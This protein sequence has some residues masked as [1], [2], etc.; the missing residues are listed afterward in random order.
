MEFNKDWSCIL[1]R[2]EQKY[3][4]MRLREKAR[5]HIDALRVKCF[6][7][8]IIFGF[9]A[10]TLSQM[11]M[12]FTCLRSTNPDLQFISKIRDDVGAEALDDIELFS[13]NFF[14]PLKCRLGGVF[15][16]Y[17]VPSRLALTVHVLSNEIGP[18]RWVRSVENGIKPSGRAFGIHGEAL[19]GQMRK[20]AGIFPLQYH[21]LP[22]V[23]AHLPTDELRFPDGGRGV[24]VEYQLPGPCSGEGDSSRIASVMH[25]VNVGNGPNKRLQIFHLHPEHLDDS[26]RVAADLRG[27]FPYAFG[28]VL[29]DDV[30][31]EAVSDELDNA[32]AIPVRKIGRVL[33]LQVDQQAEEVGLFPDVRVI[34]DDLRNGRYG[35][36][37]LGPEGCLHHVAAADAAYVSLAGVDV[38]VFR[39]SPFHALH[40]AI[41]RRR[42]RKEVVRHRFGRESLVVSRQRDVV[43]IQHRLRL[44]DIEHPSAKI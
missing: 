14:L 8:N 32:S 2:S 37:A 42:F 10:Q 22:D 39:P 20:D 35:D 28:V 9:T 24:P 11:D 26:Q 3:I 12:N 13:G 34:P 21:P 41:H 30:D 16:R 4:H 19:V 33:L 1:D 7:E 44:V 15:H 5:M 38:H 29:A 40:V 31:A 27:R 6:I 17:P 43:K 36:V 25:D 23:F 18:I